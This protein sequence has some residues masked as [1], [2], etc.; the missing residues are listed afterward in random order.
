MIMNFWRQSTAASK[1]DPKHNIERLTLKQRLGALT[2]IPRFL[3][4]VYQTSPWITITN[5]TIRLCLAVLPIIMLYIG[6]LIIDQIVTIVKHN[7]GDF[8][9]SHVWKYVIIEFVLVIVMNGLTKVVNL[10]DT[11]LGDLFAN[12]TSLKIMAHAATLDLDQ[13]E[14]SIFYDKLE[15][16]RLQSTGRAMLLTQVLTQMQ[17]VITMCFLATGLILFNPWFTFILLFS[18]IPSFIG[19]YY[20]NAKTYSLARSQMARRR[21]LEYISYVGASDQ[22]AKEVR[23]FDTSGFFMNRYRS[24]F[25][26]LYKD[27][28]SLAKRRTLWG[29][30][31][32]MLGTIGYYVAFI[33][34]IR[35]VIAGLLTI[36]S[37]TFLLGSIRQLGGTLQSVI[38]RFSTVSQ[39]ALY[40][41]DFFDFFTIKSRMTV[42]ANPRPFPKPIKHGFTFEN[43][44]FQYINTTRWANRNL[45]FTL[46]AGEKLALVGENGAGKTTLVKLLARLY[47]PT[48]G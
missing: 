30:G 22:T 20:F 14:D 47:D 8:S 11:L 35:Q 46:H 15:R 25:L 42:P 4:L 1:G 28:S 31:L 13:F 7:N 3:K 39:G 18:T 33:F 48:E 16:A 2:N 12:H 45:N 36:G 24:I 17:D 27:T 23:V 5:S 26:K 29:V 10:F 9:H 37:L 19:E 34:I 32:T 6:K 21:E 40:L 44:G 38:R 43:V 41:T